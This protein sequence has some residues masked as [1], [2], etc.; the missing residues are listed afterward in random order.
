MAGIPSASDHVSQH[1]G[2]HFMA[3][4]LRALGMCTI[5]HK[6]FPIG[7]RSLVFASKII[8]PLECHTK[9]RKP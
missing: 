3:T 5:L 1:F 7:C 9:G 2:E 6:F 4:A 8:Y